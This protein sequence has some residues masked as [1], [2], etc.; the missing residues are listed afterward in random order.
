MCEKQ[1]RASGI[2]I[3]RMASLDFRGFEQTS[4]ILALDEYSNMLWSQPL[5]VCY[6]DCEAYMQMS[7]LFP[8]EGKW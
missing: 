3:G 4:D 7:I 5:E 2:L 8:T 6:W 1:V